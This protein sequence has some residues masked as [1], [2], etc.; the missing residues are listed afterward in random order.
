M[1]GASN[2]LGAWVALGVLATPAPPPRLPAPPAARA[3]SDAP[4]ASASTDVPAAPPPTLTTLPPLRPEADGTL[5]YTDPQGRFTAIIGTDGRVEFRDRAQ[6][7]FGLG[8]F[9]RN[10]FLA[11][12]AAVQWI[13]AMVG[14]TGR[15]GSYEGLGYETGTPDLDDRFTRVEDGME[16]APPSPFRYG[17]V[18]ILAGVHGKIGGL[19]DL[20][21]RQDQRR[22]ADAKRAFLE[23]TAS[24]RA[25]M[26]AR[27]ERDRRRAA[28]MASRAELRAIWNDEGLSAAARRQ[29]LFEWWDDCDEGPLRLALDDDMWRLQDTERIQ[30]AERMRRQIEAFVRRVAPSGSPEAFTAAELRRL[31]AHR[32]SRQRFTPYTTRTQMDSSNDEI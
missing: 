9:I 4:A 12:A 27:I 13:R 7:R 21:L 1:F 20:L 28:F 22:H 25:Q 23:Q 5:R 2:V 3:P 32:R 24:L 6:A 26:A 30:D 29:M 16:K 31:N 19:S 17:P 18:A 8:V 11:G 10:E 15:R 14:A